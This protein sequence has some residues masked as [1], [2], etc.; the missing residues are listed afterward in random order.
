[1]LVDAPNLTKKGCSKK[2]QNPQTAEIVFS[3][4]GGWPNGKQKTT[5]FLSL[6]LIRLV[7]LRD[8]WIASH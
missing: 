4:V 6:C 7:K 8:L 1:M 3:V 2:V 5:D